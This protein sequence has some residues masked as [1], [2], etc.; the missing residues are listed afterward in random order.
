MVKNKVTSDSENKKLLIEY[1]FKFDVRKIQHITSCLKELGGDQLG[2]DE[3]ATDIEII[4]ALGEAQKHH[5]SIHEDD[6][7]RLEPGQW[8]NDAIVEFWVSW[9]SR[10]RPNGGVY[11]LSTHFYTKFDEEGLKGVKNWMQ[12]KRRRIPIFEKK[13]IFVPINGHGHWSLS[14]IVNPGKIMEVY[15]KNVN[16]LTDEEKE[17]EWPW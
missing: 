7:K 14:V 15:N 11:F 5:I 9:I 1:P 6:K 10:F 3:V 13:L 12:S 8:L 2:V 17:M 4:D 16:S